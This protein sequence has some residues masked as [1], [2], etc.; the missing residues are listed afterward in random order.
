MKLQPPFPTGSIQYFSHESACLQH[1]PLGD[2]HIRTHTLYLPA[3]ANDPLPLL[4]NLAGFLGSGF[5]SL[6]WR[7][8]QESLPQRL[9]RLIAHGHMPPVAILFPDCFTRLGGNQFINSAGIGRYADFLCEELVPFVETMYGC[10]GS[11]K[12]GVFGKSSGGY[13]AL[14]HGMSAAGT[15]HITNGFWSAVACH[16]GDMGFAWGY[17]S[18]FPN[19]LQQ[20]DKFDSS[21][22][23]FLRHIEHKRKPS[24]EEMEALMTL[25][26][27][28]TYDPDPSAFMGIRLPVTLDTCEWIPDRWRNWLR[29]DPLEI[30]EDHANA[31]RRLKGLFIDCGTKDQYRLHF[32]ARRLHRKLE[33]LG[34]PHRYEEFPDTHSGIDYR[35][36]ESLVY[37]ARCV[38]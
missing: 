1:N 6:N 20:L 3:A 26:M 28:A 25:A 17:A 11:G 10:G 29:H 19:C 27:A 33:K 7:P 15:S 4:V 36:D 18:D 2:P 9:D 8:F 34:V 35:L 22:E 16:S 13:G 38:A 37:L 32:G 23:G 14:M 5:S 30:V 21:I 24:S 31:L 12:R